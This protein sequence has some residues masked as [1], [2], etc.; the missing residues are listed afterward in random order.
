[1]NP[2]S[3]QVERH[4]TALRRTE[5]SR[6]VRLAL[7]GGLI[8]PDYSVFDYGCGHGGD[9][10]RL[11]S[12]GFTCR[13]WDPVH[14]PEGTRVPSDVVN[15][16]YIVNVI[17]D[18]RE[19][20]D[21]LRQAWLL[22]NRLLIVSAQLT[23]DA[24]PSELRPYRD[25]CVTRLNTFQKY[26]E[27]QELREWIDKELQAGSIPAAPGVFYLFKD[28]G[29]A[30]HYLH[31]RLRRRIA[32]PRQ[33][34][35]DL[36]FERHKLL[37][38]A[39]MD[40][41]ADRGRV[42]EVA[43]LEVGAEL[44]EALGSVKRAFAVVRKVTGAEQWDLIREERAQ[45]LL[46]YIA[47]AKFDGRPAFSLLPEELQLDV[48]AHF[49]S[50]KKACALA[51]ELLF[52]VGNA[53]EV[54]RACRRSPIG[55]QTPTALYFQID[56]LPRLAPILRVYEG[57][58][59]AYV[60]SVEDANIIKMHRAKPQI[61]Y[62]SYPEFE[63]DPHPALT[64]SLKVRFR[65]LQIEYRD[66]RQSGNPF[67]LHRKEEFLAEDHPLRARAVR[68]TKQEEAH[69]LFHEPSQI[70]TRRAWEEALR[71]RGVVLRGHRLVKA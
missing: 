9:V 13:G 44:V 10:R 52:A 66:Y 36:L 23:A 35:S 28:P 21:T 31:S 56:V 46:V 69:G 38:A 16:G 70:G 48:R 12:L 14:H 33:R 65:G 18:S 50:Y 6:P 71:V 29:L 26:Y 63:R 30:Q 55:K 45:D 67:I 32:V 1:M 60:G 15:L 8:R 40:F 5:L 19:R 59:R 62:L 57:C 27:Q 41:Y 22:A 4:R 3:P 49:S 2:D 42:P 51:D 37:F 43:E 47:L 61:S 68:L 11:Q 58:A 54:D 17:E 34:Q 7:N 25:G 64:E 39:L 24:N 53:D 20:S